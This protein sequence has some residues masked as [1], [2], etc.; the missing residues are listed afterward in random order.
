VEHF[1]PQRELKPTLPKCLFGESTNRKTVVLIL[2]ASLF[3]VSLFAGAQNV[4]ADSGD[5]IVYG[6]GLTLFSPLNVTYSSDQLTLNLSFSNGAGVHCILNY[7][8][9]GQ[10]NGTIP[11]DFG[12]STGFHSFVVANSS[13]P[14]PELSNGSHCLTINVVAAVN[15]YH[16]NP[17]GAPFQ[18]VDPDQGNW[19]ATWVHT[20]YFTVDAN[21]DTPA[22]TPTLTMPSFLPQDTLSPPEAEPSAMAEIPWTPIAIVVA[23]FSVLIGAEIVY[24]MV[25][26]KSWK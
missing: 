19:A 8:I 25:K 17:L 2:L 10:T 16:G 3:G 22:P 23:A 5:A 18:L 6:S 20:V 1:V 9:D 4:A 11:L 26:R 21:Q 12:N 14:L 7:S 24:V 15:G 13:I